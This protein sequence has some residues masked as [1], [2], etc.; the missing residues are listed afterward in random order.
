VDWYVPQKFTNGMENLVLQVLQ[1]QKVDICHK[2]PGGASKVITD[3]ISALW[4]V[5]LMLA[6]NRSLLNREQTLINVLKPLA[7]IISVCNLHVILLSKITPSY[8]TWLMK[9]MFHWVNVRWASGGLNLWE[10]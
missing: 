4:R 10:K 8:F 6:F 1:F 5:S 2:F 7:S 9:G 3:L